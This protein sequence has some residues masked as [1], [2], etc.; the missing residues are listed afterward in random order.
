MKIPK[1]KNIFFGGGGEEFEKKL[2]GS[3]GGVR[4]VGSGWIRPNN[5]GRHLG[6]LIGH[7]STY[8]LSG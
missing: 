2:G 3:R 8:V 1:K 7:N 4:M 6:K 5:C